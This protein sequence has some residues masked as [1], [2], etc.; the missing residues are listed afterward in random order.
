MPFKASSLEDLHALILRGN[1]RYPVPI[2]DDAKDLI[3]RMLVVEPTDRISI[4]QL[5][6]HPWLKKACAGEFNEDSEDEHDFMVGFSFRRD[7]CNFDPIMPQSKKKNSDSST[8]HDTQQ[9]TQ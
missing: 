5:F 9:S 8:V 1:I 2:S 4:P 7:Q 6:R 3:E